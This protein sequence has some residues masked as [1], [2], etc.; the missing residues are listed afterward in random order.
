VVKKKPRPCTARTRD[1]LTLD[2]H[3]AILSAW[4]TNNRVTIRLV[5]Q[6]PPELWQAAIPGVPH[7][8]IRMIAAHLHNSRCSWIKTLGL[9]HGLAV[10]VRVDYR[11]V[12]RRRLTAALKR[13]SRSM[14]ALLTLGVASGG[15]LPASKRYVWRNLPLDVAHVLAYFVAHEAHHRGQIVLVARQLNRRLPR[16]VTGGLWWWSTRA[17]ERSRGSVK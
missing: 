9:E 16:T 15:A 5:E 11:T 3:T 8:T 10:P 1:A 4:Q 6:L 13:S 14:E 12:S 17:T 7:R 2:L